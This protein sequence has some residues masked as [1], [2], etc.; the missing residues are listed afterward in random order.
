MR[1]LTVIIITIIINIVVVIIIIAIGRFAVVHY[2][3]FNW[4]LELK[5]LNENHSNGDQF[6]IDNER[7]ICPKSKKKKCN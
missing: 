4:Q 5:D 7:T 1:I 6:S 2:A 3:I